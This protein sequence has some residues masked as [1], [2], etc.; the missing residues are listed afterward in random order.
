MGG[1]VQTPKKISSG[2]VQV[3]D[4]LNVF[5]VNDNCFSKGL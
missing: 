5:A 2:F 1:H 3:D 4:V